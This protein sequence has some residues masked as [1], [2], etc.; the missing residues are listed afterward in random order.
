MSGGDAHVRALMRTISVSE[1]N[2][3]DPYSIMYGGQ[4]ALALDRHPD[5]CFGIRV[6]VNTGDCSTAAGRYQFITTTWNEKSSRYDPSGGGNFDAFH[7]DQV[8]YKWLSDPA[9]WGGYNIP[10][11]LKDG[12]VDEVLAR[13]SGTWTSLGS[14][15]ETNSN[16]ASL[17]SAY[18]AFLKAE[19]GGAPVEA[20]IASK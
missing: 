6:G 9:A 1:S 7:Q 13:L 2:V 5:L 15:I 10:Q 12:R 16:T 17:P 8:A 20:G 4:R 3:P 11:A 14:G 18:R 19:E